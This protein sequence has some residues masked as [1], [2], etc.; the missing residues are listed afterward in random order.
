MIAAIARCRASALWCACALL[1]AAGC[2][3]HPLPPGN[4]GEGHVAPEGAV[5]GEYTVP[6]C[7]AGCGYRV[8]ATYPHD[9][10]AFTQ[11]LEFDHGVLYEGTGLYRQ[12]TLRRVALESGVPEQV[13]ALDDQY[14][15]EGITVLDGKVYQL[16]WRE[17]IALV[18]DQAT[19]A[20]VGSLAYTG[21]GWG[22]TNDGT[23]LIMSDG[24]SRLYFRDPATFAVTREIEV[25]GGRG[26]VQNLNELEYIDDLVYANVWQSDTLVQ[27]NPVS[28]A[29]VGVV[30]LRGLLSP[31]EARRADV[32]NGIAWDAEA[33]RLFVTGKRWPKLFQIQLTSARATGK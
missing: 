19:L 27:I 26:P 7:A 30:D 4:E 12:S 21:E 17:Q 14:F 20:L 13:I 23:S 24:S 1:L 22:L 15:G 8:V 10:N 18:Y 32:L 3:Q 29:V 31:A 25:R 16:T 11:G 5:E 2:T 33:K 28:G 6:D 9:T